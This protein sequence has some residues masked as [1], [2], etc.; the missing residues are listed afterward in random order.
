MEIG[1]VVD[2]AIDH[3]DRKL[4][5]CAGVELDNDE[6]DEMRDTLQSILETREGLG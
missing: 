1:E 4:A 2:N 5:A 3:M 6:L